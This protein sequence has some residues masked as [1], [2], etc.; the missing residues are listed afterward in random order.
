MRILIISITVFLIFL[1]FFGNFNLAISNSF[2][3]YLFYLLNFFVKFF[4]FFLII[5]CAVS[6]F[7]IWRHY[8]KRHTK[9]KTFNSVL[10]IFEVLI[11]SVFS[12][13]VFLLIIGF[14]QLNIFS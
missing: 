2:I 1:A 5:F 13:F 4:V 7:L 12:A 8:T 6:A 10:Q 9:K 14:L 3:A 11:I